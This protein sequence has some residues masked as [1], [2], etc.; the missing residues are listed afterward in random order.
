M[1]SARAAG[2]PRAPAARRPGPAPALS[3]PGAV[4]H[5]RP[6]RDS[7]PW[8]ERRASSPPSRLPRLQL[9]VDDVDDVLDGSYGGEL[10][11]LQLLS[12]LDLERDGHIDPVDAVEIE[13]FDEMRLGSELIGGEPERVL[14]H[15]RQLPLHLGLVPRCSGHGV[16]NTATKL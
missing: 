4:T 7:R 2:R 5:R 15:L 14:P 9:S 6:G 12:R 8:R 16:R 11:L 13:V 3:A 10:L 1:A